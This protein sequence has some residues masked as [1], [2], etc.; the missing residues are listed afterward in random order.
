M[1][2]FNSGRHVSVEIVKVTEEN[3]VEEIVHTVLSL[4]VIKIKCTR[5]KCLTINSLI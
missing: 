2:Q 3:S 5:F 1:T 4:D